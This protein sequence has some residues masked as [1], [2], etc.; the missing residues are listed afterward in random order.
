MPQST[1]QFL[2]TLLSP[3]GNHIPQLAGHRNSRGIAR[4]DSDTESFVASNISCDKR[5]NNNFAI[6]TCCR[7]AAVT[8]LALEATAKCH[9]RQ[10]RITHSLSPFPFIRRRRCRRRCVGWICST[11]WIMQAEH[12]CASTTMATH[13]HRH[14]I[15]FFSNV[16]I[17]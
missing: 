13:T 7:W 2:T 15:V 16:M 6:K 5:W 11:S 4:D 1:Q 3:T 14:E 10:Q 17:A 12:M 9:I 8:G